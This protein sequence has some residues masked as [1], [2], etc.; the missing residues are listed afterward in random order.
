MIG[1][2]PEL[3]IELPT[4]TWPGW[5]LD[6]DFGRDA[7]SNDKEPV[8]CQGKNEGVGVAVTG[9]TDWADYTISARMYIHLADRAGIIARYQGLKRWIG[10]CQNGDTLQ[11][12]VN[13]Y[14]EK[15]IA[16]RPR[17]CAVDV[18]HEYKLTVTGNRIQA[19][20]DGEPMFDVTDDTLTSGGAGFL[21]DTGLIGVR[22]ISI[23]SKTETA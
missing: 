23:G 13:H 11:L 17:E 21:F 16:E 4:W 22:D 6:S 18:L 5:I 15:V 1:G 12:I 2:S 14:G 19:F 7:F 20:V 9:N 8:R 10:L 3:S